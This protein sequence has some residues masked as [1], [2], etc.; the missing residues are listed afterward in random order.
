MKFLQDK[1]LYFLVIF[2]RLFFRAFHKKS[3]LDKLAMIIYKI[4]KKHRKIVHANLKFAFEGTSEEEVTK[5]AKMVYKNFFSYMVELLLSDKRDR[6]S[7]KPLV[8]FKN[9][10]SI[11][12]AIEEGENFIFFSAHFCNF[13]LLVRYSAEFLTPLS[14]I[15]EQLYN[16]PSL[17]KLLMDYTSSP[18]ITPY[19]RKGAMKKLFY[20][21]KHGK[22]VSIAT[23]QNTTPTEGILI[24]F[25][26]KKA[27]HTPT[28]SQLSRRLN[29]RLVP[30]FI[31]KD[32]DKYIIEFFE[33]IAPDPSLSVDDDVLRLTQ[34]QASMTEKMI[35]KYPSEYFW[36]H[37]RFKNQY[38][39]IYQ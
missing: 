8:E 26:G 3:F 32:D 23:D 29:I 24:D 21:I 17:T 1:F 9:H 4:D 15:R 11:L 22:S 16:S 5:N 6:E 7:L 12:K 34:F 18:N 28:A 39:H 31:T 25:F 20:D 2:L 38:P 14:V 33:P 37:R 30:A 35:R 13:E 10:E 19:P 27:R 36:L